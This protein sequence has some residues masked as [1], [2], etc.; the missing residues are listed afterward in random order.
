[1]ELC[2]ALSR[3][4]SSNGE[5]LQGHLP[6]TLAQSAR[7]LPAAGDTDVTA[8]RHAVRTRGADEH[9]RLLSQEFQSSL[10]AEAQ[11]PLEGLGGGLS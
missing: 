3:N 1:M 11:T 4:C 7:P 6:V 9:G 8:R 2:Q 10:E 5:N